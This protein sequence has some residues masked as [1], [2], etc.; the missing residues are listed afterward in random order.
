LRNGL[1]SRVEARR[2]HRGRVDTH[3][4]DAENPQDLEI[5]EWESYIARYPR[6]KSGCRKLARPLEMATGQRSAHARTAAA[7][8]WPRPCPR[9]GSRRRQTTGFGNVSLQRAFQASFSEPLFSNLACETILYLS[10]LS[11]LLSSLPSCRFC[12]LPSCLPASLPSQSRS[13]PS[14]TAAAFSS[15]P[16]RLSCCFCCSCRRCLQPS[17][18]PSQSSP[19]LPAESALPAWPAVVKNQWPY[20]TPLIYGGCCQSYFRLVRSS[21][22][23]LSMFASEFRS[24]A[25]CT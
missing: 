25:L 3:R 21:Q 12:L 4:R 5:G 16:F 8:S 23:S 15:W 24:A 10:I 13:F 17:P 14:S 6:L 1:R 11:C 20:K 9:A 19:E 7:V 18:P 2:E 22:P